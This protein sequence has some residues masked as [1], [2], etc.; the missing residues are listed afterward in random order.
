MKYLILTIFF[1]ISFVLPVIAEEPFREIDF[2]KACLAA[3]EEKKVVLIDFFTT[4]CGPCKRMDAVTWKDKDVMAWLEKNTIALKIDAEKEVDLAKRYKISAYPTVAI[5]RPDGT[6]V[7]QLVGF[8]DAKTFL[9]NASDS[10]IGKTALVKAE[11]EF[12]K[13]A[14]SPKTRSNYA[15][16][17]TRAGKYEEALTHYAWCFDKGLEYDKSYAGVRAS[18]LLG[19]IGSLARKHKPAMDF[20][21]ERRAI[22]EKNLLSGN[23]ENEV[24]KIATLFE[25]MGINRNLGKA[26]LENNLAFYNTLKERK[27][28][29]LE[30]YVLDN[31]L[32]ELLKAKR[33]KDIVESATDISIRIEKRILSYN[34]LVLYSKERPGNI[35][36]DILKHSKDDVVNYGEQ[37][38]RAL[39]G[40]NDL[41]QA[42]KLAQQISNF[43]STP[44]TFSLLV[45]TA[46][47]FDAKDLAK[48]LSEQASKI[49]V[50]KKTET[51]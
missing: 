41:E 50:E 22:A 35:S 39:L 43:N 20:L 16:E 45:K 1:L 42:K 2:D 51:K 30:G 12:T 8:V 44:E 21:I 18:F 46:E 25:F 49:T 17:L 24:E 32:A 28:R 31:I 23:G 34:S 27:E 26:G 40:T 3:K 48:E 7:D 5:I 36:E 38:F 15:R 29:T 33:Y 9:T 47:E 6:E 11:E 10:L 19:E 13:N 37:Y 4:W 14:N